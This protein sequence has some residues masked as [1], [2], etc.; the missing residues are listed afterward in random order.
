MASNGT[1]AEGKLYHIRVKGNLDEKWADWFGG[2]VMASRSGGETLL[3]GRVADQA[4]LHGILSKISGLDHPLL[5]AAQ[6]DCPCSAKRCQRHG[7]C[8]EC[9]AHHAAS[10]KLPFCFREKTR[11]DKHCAALA[12]GR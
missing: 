4:A 12:Q 8:Q 7:H 1:L 6:I 11:W 5:L 2:F 9:N 10:G 3:T